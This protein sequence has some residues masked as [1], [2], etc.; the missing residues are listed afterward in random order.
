MDSPTIEPAHRPPSLRSV[1]SNASLSSNLTRR[2]RTRTRSKTTTS[3]RPDV[4]TFRPPITPQVPTVE[5]Q[6]YADQLVAEP[7]DIGHDVD[8]REDADADAQSEAGAR[9]SKAAAQALRLSSI[10]T[11]QFKPPPSAFSRVP[12]IPQLYDLSN[13][14]ARDSVFT[15]GSGFTQS[16]GSSSIYPPST[17]TASGTESPP[18]PRSIAEQDDSH[19]VS[20]F[21]PELE[22]QEYDGDDVSYRLRLLVKNNYFLPPAH[23]K[24]SSSD[25]AASVN[26]KK[27]S[28]PPPTPTFFD[29]FRKSRSKPSTPTASPQTLDFF[30][31]VL[32]TT[33]D[34]T[35]VSGYAPHQ[36]RRRSSS[37]APPHPGASQDPSGRVVVVR[38]KMHDIATAAK[39]A[40]Q[41]MNEVDI[42]DPTDAVD[43]PP[44]S[45][46]YPFAVQ[47]SALHGMGVQD[48]VGAAL[49]ADCL[50]P[51]S[52]GGVSVDH[53]WRK[54]LLQAAVGHS[55]NSASGI[56]SSTQANPMS[57]VSSPVSDTRMLGQRIMSPP[58]DEPRSSSTSTHSPMVDADEAP[59][60]SSTLPQ[61]V[62]TPS[63]P[64]M[65][66]PPPRRLVNPLYSISQT[67]LPVDLE[68]TGLSPSSAQVERIESTPRLS[69]SYESGVRHAMMSPPLI[70]RE[71]SEG[72]S[73]ERSRSSSDSNA[74]FYSEEEEDAD[75]PRHSI[76]SSI[77]DARPSLSI[78]SQPSP[79]TS[80]FQD[81]I[82]YPP[83]VN[84]PARGSSLRH[85]LEH[86][87]SPSP[88]PRDSMASPPPRV[89]SSL[90]HL[91]PL[92]PPPRSSSLGQRFAT[93]SRVP[94]LIPTLPTVSSESSEILDPGPS[95][96]PFP[97]SGRRG[98]TPLVLEIPQ[99]M[100]HPS[101]RSAPAPSA[102]PSFFD[103]IQNQPNA[104]DDLDSSDDDDD[105]SYQDHDEPDPPH[106]QIF[107]ER[108]GVTS[109]V[110]PPPSTA[111]SRS[112]L[113]RLGNHSTPY[114]GRPPSSPVPNSKKP[115]SNIPVAGSFFTERRGGKSDQGHGPP[116]VHVRLLP[117]RAA[118]PIGLLRRATRAAPA[119]HRR[120]GRARL[121]EQPAGAGVFAAAG[122]DA[123]STH[124]GGKRHYQAYCY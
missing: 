77:P 47:A 81:A 97:I 70:S 36:P 15:Q 93:P 96:P 118:A 55:L 108:T 86:P 124:G 115:I 7:M 53:D 105:D 68:P 33:S 24:P 103:S 40:E 18:S 104:M 101:I 112:L 63:M 49:L 116:T 83:V 17:S 9:H 95:T 71:S 110:P 2:S 62:E 38:E 21:D 84:P 82:G 11:G 111:S 37:Q 31:P 16:G 35:T 88:V 122:R 57:S 119:T 1:A 26:A 58:I 6:L 99:T 76:S 22:L 30:T 59:R 54:A 44:P 79:T 39:Q 113:M 52:P 56:L 85:S 41:E 94:P 23:S 121:A 117:V 34:S 14:N 90:A 106:T 50:P 89:S 28:R 109:N 123:D 27:A 87:S 20:S 48:S 74:S 10:S 25:F 43:L 91:T 19:G 66:L 98:T 75:P 69:D 45:A 120:P 8:Q 64:M 3:P 73:R 67:S 12:D 102:P 46:A 78:Y 80:A 65:P 92:S 100:I 32:R 29:M 4:T 42:I 5:P 114:V 72:F 107:V 51:R 13:P 61:R 60:P